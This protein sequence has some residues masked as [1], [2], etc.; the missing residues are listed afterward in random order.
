M[1]WL[2]NCKVPFHTIRWN[3]LAVVFALRS[4]NH[5]WATTICFVH[6][7][8]EFSLYYGEIQ[9]IGMGDDF[10][11]LNNGNLNICEL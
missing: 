1:G 9:G 6:L 5:E 10:H 3:S 8:K 4:E 2:I 11:V 7:G